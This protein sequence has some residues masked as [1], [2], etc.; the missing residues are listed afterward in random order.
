MPGVN[1]SW[2]PE[3][4]REYQNVDISVA[5]QTP[6]GLFTPIV[7]DADNKRMLSISSDVMELAKKVGAAWCVC[8]CVCVCVRARMRAWVVGEWMGV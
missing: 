2:N 7:K 6:K 1:A 4:I 3:F 5:V 8:V